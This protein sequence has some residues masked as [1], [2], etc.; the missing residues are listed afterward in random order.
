MMDEKTFLD[1]LSKRRLIRAFKDDGV[2]DSKL[3]KILEACN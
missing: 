1:F 3:S 2:D